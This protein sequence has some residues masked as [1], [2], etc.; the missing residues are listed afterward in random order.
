[1]AANPLIVAKTRD[2]FP[3]LEIDFMTWTSGSLAPGL[4]ALIIMPWLLRRMCFTVGEL[5][6]CEAA[7]RRARLLAEGQLDCLGPMSDKEKVPTRNVFFL[8][9]IL[10]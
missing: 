8:C 1:M 7:T 10:V 5:V 6:E 9:P 2:I 4:T 3:T